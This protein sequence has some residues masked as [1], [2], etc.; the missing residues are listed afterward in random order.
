MENAVYVRL[1]PYNPKAGHLVKNYN[2]PLPNGKRQH[3]SVDSNDR[4]VW[5]K[6]DP[7]TAVGLRD[8]HQSENPSTPLLFDILDDAT[9]HQVVARENDLRLVELGLMSATMAAPIM[10]APRLVDLA[11]VGRAAAMPDDDA[12]LSM[13]DSMEESPRAAA[14]PQKARPP[15]PP[16]DDFD[17]LGPVDDD[18]PPVKRGPGRPRKQS[19]EE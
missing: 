19:V 5:Y 17:D 2:C 18:A 3:F 16:A 10:A 12:A 7:K 15:A 8:L 1:K 14:I 9:Y 4:P 11:P 13:A 6:M